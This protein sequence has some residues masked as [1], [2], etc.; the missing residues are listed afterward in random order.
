[1]SVFK[2]GAERLE[3][4]VFKEGQVKRADSEIGVGSVRK[5]SAEKKKKKGMGK[6]G[7]PSTVRSR[8]VDVQHFCGKR[9]MDD[10]KKR[11]G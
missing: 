4:I 11:P 1:L 6:E 8:N 9:K 10:R 2:K 7:G 3:Q 5:R